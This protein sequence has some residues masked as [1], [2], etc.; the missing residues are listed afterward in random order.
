MEQKYLNT[1]SVPN[2]TIFEEFDSVIV[3]I[4][5]EF[6]SQNYFWILFTAFFLVTF[7]SSQFYNDGIMD[8]ILRYARRFTDVL[9]ILFGLLTV[10]IPLVFIPQYIAHKKSND[11][12]SFFHTLK[13]HSR[14]G[15]VIL[16][17]LLAFISF[18][19]FMG[20]FVY[21][22]EK[23]GQ[24]NDYNWDLTFAEWDAALFSGNQAWEVLHPFLGYAPVTR[25]IDFLY[26]FWVLL[27]ALIWIVVFSVQQI[28]TQ[29][30]HQ[31]LLSTF[32]AWTVIGLFAATY[33]ASGGP[34][35]YH[36]FTGD[37]Q[38]YA[39]L[40]AYLDNFTKIDAAGQPIGTLK[41]VSA[42]YYLWQVHTGLLETPGGISAMPSMHNAQVI[43]FVLITYKYSRLIGHLML[44]Y[45]VVIF[46]GSIH[47]AW[48]YAVDGIIAF[49][50]IVPIWF[51][52]GWITGVYAS[53][54]QLRH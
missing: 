54:K 30:K 48:H 29:E 9:I 8:G 52:S 4:K 17:I 21:W 25:F 32:L 24:F 39:G 44:C 22:K 34:V 43:L 31:Y 1:H 41:A 46:L 26:F 18:S 14:K 7:I 53:N 37:T 12:T 2:N 15:I 36:K 13:K 38:M 10:V 51:A 33:F 45:A 3:S 28:S 6:Q 50:M 5:K 35:Y 19:I 16:R 23:I 27:T 49:V 11:S 20:C 42:Q 40:L 47:L